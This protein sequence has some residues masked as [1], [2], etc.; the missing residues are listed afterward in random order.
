MQKLFL[1]IICLVYVSIPFS[2]QT[3]STP[4]DNLCTIAI[5]IKN[6]ET[7]EVESHFE[8]NKPIKKTLSFV[9]DKNIYD[10]RIN[11]TADYHYTMDTLSD[12][13]KINFTFL[14]DHVKNIKFTYKIPLKSI[15]YKDT[16]GL[17]LMNKSLVPQINDDTHIH[18]F[19]YEII[20]K[21]IT[22][23][24][25]YITNHD[26]TDK[27]LTDRIILILSNNKYSKLSK[28]HINVFSTEVTDDKINFIIK[29]TEKIK[30]SRNN[31]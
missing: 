29:E 25:Y 24:K 7:I 27:N 9:I 11:N 31:Y 22:P 3:P 30:N 28:N 12:V 19:S 8:F 10:I 13:K 18:F 26:I 1:I 17:L 21:N 16:S 23:Y 15:H 20:P 14:S 6:N 2:C 4:K 5:D